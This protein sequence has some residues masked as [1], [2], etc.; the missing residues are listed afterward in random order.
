MRIAMLLAILL[1]LISSDIVAAQQWRGIEILKSNCEDVKRSLNVDKC[2]YPESTYRL[3]DETVILTFESCPCPVLCSQSHG[4]WNVPPGTVSSIIRQLR[5][6][7]PIADYNVEDDKWKRNTTDFDGQVIYNNQEQGLRLST[8]HRMVESITYYPTLVKH[9]DRLCPPCSIPPTTDDAD[10]AIHSIWFDAYGNIDVAEQ[11]KHL[12]MF[13]RKIR[14]Q[15]EAVL[16][17]IVTYDGCRERGQAAMSAERAKNY[18]VNTQK[19]DSSR[20]I[21][22]DGGQRDEQY[23]ELHVR[24]RALPPPR[25]FSSTY[26]I[27]TKRPKRSK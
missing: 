12:D 8:M 10:Q 17:Y 23:F 22:I 26:P 13:A 27:E 16:G 15:G 6:P 9:K 21:V 19:V 7:L 14:E 3:P 24:A 5:K 2:S 20:I 11:E 25:T 4:G 1:L 18:L